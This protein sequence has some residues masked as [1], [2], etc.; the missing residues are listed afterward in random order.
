[1]VLASR[2]V[3]APGREVCVWGGGMVSAKQGKREDSEVMEMFYV[4]TGM[5]VTGQY[6]CRNSISHTLKI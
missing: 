4:L 1:M 6:A 5:L 2:T 3:A